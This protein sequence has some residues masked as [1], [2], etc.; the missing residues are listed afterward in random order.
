MELTPRYPAL[1]DWWIDQG[2]LTFVHTDFRADNFLIGG[3]AGD[4][5]VTLLDWQLSLRGAGVWDIANFLAASITTENRR[6]WESDLLDRY[7]SGLVAG[8]VTDYS[9]DR[10]WRDYRYAIAQQAWSTCPMGDVDPGN[11]RGQLLLD[12]VTPRYLQAAD[13]LDAYEVLGLF[14]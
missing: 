3:S 7:H 1:L 6:T 4:G 8:G 2:H 12:T 9:R 14:R 5:V 10:C 11:E 13:D